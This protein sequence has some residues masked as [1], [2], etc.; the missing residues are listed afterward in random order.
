M[1]FRLNQSFCF[2]VPPCSHLRCGENNY[3]FTLTPYHIALL[4]F[5]LTQ[6]HT[7]FM[8]LTHCLMWGRSH[9]CVGAKPPSDL[10]RITSNVCVSQYPHTRTH[11]ILPKDLSAVILLRARL[12]SPPPSH[13]TD[14]TAIH[15]TLAVNHYG[16]MAA[17]GLPEI[18][19]HRNLS[20]DYTLHGIHIFSGCIFVVVSRICFAYKQQL[21]K[22]KCCLWLLSYYFQSLSQLCIIFI[23]YCTLNICCSK[24]TSNTAPKI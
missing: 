21:M 5:M 11:I 22:F 23:Q 15:K 1:E 20:D 19:M 16:L 18:N 7:W 17:C 4:P 6:W 12:A 8:W 14:K 3:L 13:V 2:Q 24:T 9:S 10:F